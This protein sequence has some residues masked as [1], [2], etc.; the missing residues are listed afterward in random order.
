MRIDENGW[1]ETKSYWSRCKEGKS[2]H[3]RRN[4]SVPVVV[5]A[6]MLN[7]HS[8]GCS[9][10]NGYSGGDGD[11]KV[12]IADS[13]KLLLTER[14]IQNCKA[15]KTNEYSKFT[16]GLSHEHGSTHILYSHTLYTPSGTNTNKLM[17]TGTYAHT[18]THHVQ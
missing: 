16:F 6:W 13:N 10:D 2:V 14:Y 12:K 11:E 4:T 18:A 15:S 9:K 17:Y 3:E 5:K 8:R 1:G 7:V